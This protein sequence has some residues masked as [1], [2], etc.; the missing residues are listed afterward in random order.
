MNYNDNITVLKRLFKTY[1]KKHLKKILLS[2]FFSVIL[3]GS[4]ASIAWLLDPA[5]EKIFIN[6]DK[7]LILLIPVF[8]ILAF[9]SIFIP[10]FPRSESNIFPFISWI[11]FGELLF[12][13]SHRIFHTKYLYCYHK[14]HHLNNPSYT[15]SSFDASILE[16]LIGNILPTVIPIYIIPGT[17]ILQVFY[18]YQHVS[19]K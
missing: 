12:T 11:F 17:F 19:L 14:Q 13:V 3:A 4:T 18:W 8:I 2:V 1:T 16:F 9:I 5:V 7:T 6:K 10:P 15:T